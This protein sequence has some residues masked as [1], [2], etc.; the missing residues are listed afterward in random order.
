M[1]LSDTDERA[2]LELWAET[3]GSTHAVTG[4]YER[5]VWSEFA[6]SVGRP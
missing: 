1:V 3:Y 6:L 5:W 2:D 4:D